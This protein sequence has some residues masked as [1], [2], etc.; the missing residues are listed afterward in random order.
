MTRLFIFGLGLLLL[1]GCTDPIEKPVIPADSNEPG[2]E[3]MS[4]WTREDF[5]DVFDQHEVAE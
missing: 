3:I 5:K 1:A 2:P 4:E